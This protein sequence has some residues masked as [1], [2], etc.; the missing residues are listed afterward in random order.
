VEKGSSEENNEEEEKIKWHMLLIFKQV[1]KNL[2]EGKKSMIDDLKKIFGKRG[3]DPELQAE[4]RQNQFMKEGQVFEAAIQEDQEFRYYSETRSDLVRWQQDLINEVDF[5]SHDLRSEVLKDNVWVKQNVLVGYDQ[6][7]GEL[8][9]EIPPVMNDLGINRIKSYLR[10][11]ISRN[12]INS[13][14]SEERIFKA[15]R[16]LINTIILH[17]R[18]NFHYYQIRKEDLA[19][20]VRQVKNISEPTMWRCYNNGERKYLT[21][22]HKHIEATNQTNQQDKSKPI[23]GGLT[24]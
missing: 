7:G 15:L 5:F 19:W 2:R 23:L 13:N 24:S 9:Q 21:T 22:I 18:D 11:L 1:Q 8:W 3:Q 14:Y 6:E 12:L 10:P 20:I 16:G 4:Q 17:L